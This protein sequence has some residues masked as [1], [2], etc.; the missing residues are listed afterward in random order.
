MQADRRRF[1]K[2]TGI[3]LSIAVGCDILRVSPGHARAAGLPYQ[4]LSAAEVSTL[5]RL[6]ETIVPGARDAGIAHYIDKQLTASAQDSLL[7]LKYLGIPR[8]GFADFYQGGLHSAAKLSVSHSG[9]PWAGLST[10]QANEL[11]AQIASNPEVA[12]EGPPASFFFFVLRSDACDV[13]YGT[14]AG[15]AH[16]DMPHMAHIEPREPW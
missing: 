6:A 5:E 15:I 11:V 2:S 8:A 4:V 10:D 9:K 7:M 16:I 1:L 13:V 14:T 3:V 12:W